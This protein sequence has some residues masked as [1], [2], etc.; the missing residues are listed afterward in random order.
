MAK[1]L[2]WEQPDEQLTACKPA[3]V[4]GHDKQLRVPKRLYPEC[5]NEPV[6]E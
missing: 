3:E 2:L 6:A 5:A 1:E 4:A